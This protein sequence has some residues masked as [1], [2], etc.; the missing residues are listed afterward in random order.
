M[1][2]LTQPDLKRVAVKAPLTVLPAVLAGLEADGV[3]L[4]HIYDY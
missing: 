2:I 4:E 3:K 1:P